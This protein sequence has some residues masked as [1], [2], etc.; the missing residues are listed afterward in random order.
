MQAYYYVDS[1]MPH[2]TPAGF[3]PSIRIGDFFIRYVQTT[4]AIII[5]TSHEDDGY[6]SVSVST[7]VDM[8]IPCH[9]S[10]IVTVSVT[11]GLT[12]PCNQSAM[13]TAHLIKEV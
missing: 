6:T 3:R 12:V 4:C 7:T 13:S 2:C 1:L 8:T 5:Y 11:V 10:Y 9:H